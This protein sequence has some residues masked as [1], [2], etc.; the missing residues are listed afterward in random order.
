MSAG[1][2]G[3]RIRKKRKHPP[4]SLFPHSLLSLSLP[5]S[6]LPA[7]IF[8]PFFILLMTLENNYAFLQRLCKSYSYLLLCRPNTNPF[9]IRSL[10]K[11]ERGREWT[12]ERERENCEEVTGDERMK[13][14]GGGP[15]T[16]PLPLRPESARLE[17]ERHANNTFYRQISKK[18]KKQHNQTPASS[19]SFFI[20]SSL[21]ARTAAFAG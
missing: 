8:E 3:E 2:V 7:R 17:E 11:A 18:K 4:S 1:A 16:L 20:F 14:E 5:F 12:R 6:A 9:I 19:S 21:A 15:P 13:M 10:T